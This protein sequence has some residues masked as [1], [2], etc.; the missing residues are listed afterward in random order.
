MFGDIGQPF[1]VGPARS[2]VPVDEVI[3]D[4]R[5]GFTVQSPLTGMGRPQAGH[6]AQPVDPVLRRDDPHGFEFVFDEPIPERRLS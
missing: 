2:E 3:V 5:P 6:G 4:W 1:L